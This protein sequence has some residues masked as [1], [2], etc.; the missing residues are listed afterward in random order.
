MHQSQYIRNLIAQQAA[1]ERGRLAVEQAER[2]QE[3]ADRK[4]ANEEAGRQLRA[5]VEAES[6]AHQAEVDARN[7]A[8]AEQQEAHL[9]AQ[10]RGSYSGT[11]TSFEQDWP[12][13]RAQLMASDAT[14]RRDAMRRQIGGNF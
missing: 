2:E 5:K 3:L 7:G 9:K 4:A 8:L 13:I 1:E 12:V 11:A 6:A 10:A 14:E